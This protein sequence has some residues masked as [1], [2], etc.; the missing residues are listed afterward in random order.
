M[1]VD[2]ISLDGQIIAAASEGRAHDLAR[3]LDGHP[4]KLAITGSEWNRPLL[5]IAAGRGH[6]DCVEVLLRRGFDV[7]KRDRF[8]NATALH[9]AAQ[10]GHVGVVQRLLEAGA[11]IDG[12]GDEHE[13]GVIGWST[14]FRDT[15]ETVANLLLERGAKPTIFSAVA[16]DR[17]DQVRQLVAGDRLLVARR[18]SRYE[19]HRTPLHLAVLE[20]RPR[21]VD[22][23]LEL[24]A[25]P[26]AT[27]ARGNTPLH[28]VTQKTDPAISERLIAAGASPR[29]RNANRFQAAT[30][31]L[32]VRNVPASIAY[33]IDKLGF[34]LEWDYGSPPT[35][36]SVE[37]DAVRIFLCE[38][39]QGAP[40]T[41]ISIF[42]QDV[43]A[44]YQDY[45][46]SGAII[47]QAPANFPWGVREMNVQDLDGHRLR[48]GADATGPS[49]GVNLNEGP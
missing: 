7:M 16:L 6:L 44:L 1:H 24:G 45:Q 36:A 41:W 2:G 25:D 49:D 26:S 30:P 35:F 22:L 32:N 27:D 39:G 28:D 17:A 18:M 12:E 34:Q 19:H 4:A 10:G 31:I 46:R 14:C 23:L 47:R 38:G 11:D 13:M 37:R 9:W 29:E 8:D 40:G 48:M 43:D 15:G 33:Y 21:M 20:N 3:L 42:V 5:H